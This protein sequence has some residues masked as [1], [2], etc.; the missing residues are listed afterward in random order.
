MDIENELNQLFINRA[1]GPFLFLGS[2]F[3]RRYMGLEDWQGLLNKFCVMGKPYEYYKSSANGDIARSALL[4][5]ED[6][7]DLWWSSDNYKESREKHSNIVKDKSSP[8]RIEIS[9]YLVEKQKIEK[10][11]LILT[12]NLKY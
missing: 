11:I 12:M 3:S 6:F 7:H 10:K 2:G 9:R 4:I 5:A 1:S 8:L